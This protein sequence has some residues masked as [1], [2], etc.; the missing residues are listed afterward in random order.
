[1]LKKFWRYSFSLYKACV[2]ASSP[3]L[4]KSWLIRFVTLKWLF[5]KLISS[6][7]L[8]SFYFKGSH[9]ANRGYALERREKFFGGFGPG[10]ISVVGRI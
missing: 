7:N 6:L 9:E 2:L 10:T 1:V 8:E 3:F 4:N 5:I